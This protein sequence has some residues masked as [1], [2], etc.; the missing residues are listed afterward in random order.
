MSCGQT[1]PSVTSTI[2][3]ERG[4]GGLIGGLGGRVLIESASNADS[5]ASAKRS[6]VF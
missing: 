1:I 6:I 4:S 3:A 2:W 5:A